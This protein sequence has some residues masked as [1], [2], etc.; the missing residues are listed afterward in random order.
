MTRR[1]PRSKLRILIFRHE[2]S[3]FSQSNR[4]I[5][6]ITQPVEENKGSWNGLDIPKP[7]K[8][9]RKQIEMVVDNSGDKKSAKK[10]TMQ[11]KNSLT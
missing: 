2:L 9:Q 1:K 11:V 7:P 10:V 4:D 6:I 5:E 8:N 3:V